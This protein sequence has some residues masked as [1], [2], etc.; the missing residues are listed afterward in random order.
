MQEDQQAQH[1]E[2][3]SSCTS[4]ISEICA[5]RCLRHKRA[6]RPHRASDCSGHFL[7]WRNARQIFCHQQL[8]ESWGWFGCG[9]AG[10]AC[11]RSGL[12]V[13]RGG[14][15]AASAW[16]CGFVS[17]WLRCF[18]VGAPAA[19]PV[20]RC[21]RFRWSACRVVLCDVCGACPCGVCCVSR[22]WCVGFLGV[23]GSWVFLGFRIF[24]GLGVRKLLLSL[25][26]PR[27]G[28]VLLSLMRPIRGSPQSGS[29]PEY[30]NLLPL[31]ASAFPV[32][33]WPS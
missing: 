26:S 25:M 1:N 16:R 8:R 28:R 11:V 20:L 12:G 22:L 18:C 29:S 30:R 15:A 6:C 9:W 5:V 32:C 24:Q 13:V 10:L 4:T 17:W 3:C 7:P 33:Q 31:A 19:L 2:T 23:F 27:S 21:V 14:V